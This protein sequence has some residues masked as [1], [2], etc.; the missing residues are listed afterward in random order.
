MSRAT[1]IVVAGH[2]LKFAEGLIARLAAFPR[3]EV[4]VDRWRGNHPGEHDRAQSEDLLRW[5]D[6][7]LCEWCLAN[8]VW[9]GRRK[10]PGQRLVVRLHRYEI[11]TPYPPA[12][13]VGNVDGVVFVSSHVRDLARE[14]LGWLDSPATQVIPNAVDTAAFDRPKL[15]GSERTLGMLGWVP[16]LKRL[17]RAIDILEGVRAR[18]ES[19]RLVVRGK[20]PWEYRWCWSDGEQRDYFTD[21]LDRIERDADLAEAVSFEPFGP[22]QEWF[23]GIG[24]LLSVSDFESHHLAAVEGAASGAVPVLID[25]LGAADLFDPAWVH[26]SVAAAADAIPRTSASLGEAAVEAKRFAGER[27]SYDVVMPAWASVLGLA[28]ASARGLRTA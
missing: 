10:R 7:V 28:A 19:F 3:V 25:R 15:P 1:R 13:Q 5:A 12:L 18:E 27:Y 9:Y 4:R 22:P 26:G 16:K 20:A 11:E 21:T 17:D 23:R 2:D 6:V 14:R 24:Y 8:A